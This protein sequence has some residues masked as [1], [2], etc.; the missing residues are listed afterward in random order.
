ME[1]DVR[2]KRGGGKKLLI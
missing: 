2:R 1:H